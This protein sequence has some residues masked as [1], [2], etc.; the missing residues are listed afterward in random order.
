MTLCAST[1]CT[2]EQAIPLRAHAHVHRAPRLRTTRTLLVHGDVPRLKL[3]LPGMEALGPCNNLVCLVTVLHLEHK[4]TGGAASSC[5]QSPPAWHGR[6]R[7]AKKGLRTDHTPLLET[8]HTCMLNQI[9]LCWDVGQP[10]TNK[11]VP[12]HSTN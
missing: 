5:L 1:P 6:R 2:V 11:C 7:G 12:K 8:L 4:A 3:L 9:P 10:S